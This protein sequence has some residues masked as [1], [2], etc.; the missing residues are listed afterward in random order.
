MEPYILEAV[1]TTLWTMAPNLPN[2]A[3][4]LNT[5]PHIVVTPPSH[6]IIFF[7]AS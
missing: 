4:P 1:T 2:A 3:T 6:K 7:A 5:V